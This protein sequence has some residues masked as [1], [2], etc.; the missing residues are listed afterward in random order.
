MW[1]PAACNVAFVYVEFAL[2]PLIRTVLRGGDDVL[3]VSSMLYVMSIVGYLSMAWFSKMYGLRWSL[4]VVMIMNGLACVLAIVADG[5]AAVIV[6]GRAI[7]GFAVTSLLTQTW[8][9]FAGGDAHAVVTQALYNN[10]FYVGAIS[11]VLAAGLASEYI[12][13]SYA[14]T[15]VNEIALAMFFFA[16]C[17]CFFLAED[18]APE[19]ASRLSV[20]KNVVSQKN[21]RALSTRELGFRGGVERFDWQALVPYIYGEFVTGISEGF[22]YAGFSVQLGEQYGLSDVE[23]SVV[24]VG[25]LFMSMMTN[26]FVVPRVSMRLVFVPILAI[27]WS[28]AAV[29]NLVVVVIAMAVLKSAEQILFCAIRARE[30]QEIPESKRFT[31]MVLPMSVFQVGCV[32]GVLGGLAAKNMWYWVVAVLYVTLWV[33]LRNVFF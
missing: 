20:K 21:V 17:A 33:A 16:V 9:N 23:I 27:L 18:P 24:Y 32:V 4:V 6:T 7:S 14:W 10:S 3:L 22:F 15:F 25:I 2:A 31:M 30:Y 11:G 12:S 19:H 5:H 1:I 26:L 28:I 8:M 29:N 13:K